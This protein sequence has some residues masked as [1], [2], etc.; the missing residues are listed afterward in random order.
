MK[1]NPYNIACPRCKA[2]AGDACVSVR[3]DIIFDLHKL[4]RAH[5]ERAKA[6]REQ[7][8]AR[9]EAVRA[10]LDAR[11]WESIHRSPDPGR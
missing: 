2:S 11:L 10:H 9:Q 3:E 6:S 7:E 8:E 1:P 5:P 4:D